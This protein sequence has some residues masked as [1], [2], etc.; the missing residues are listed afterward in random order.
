VII[1]IATGAALVIALG[2]F[3]FHRRVVELHHE[4]TREAVT[5]TAA[6]TK[7][8]HEESMKSLD[9]LENRWLSVQAA[10]VGVQKAM[11]VQTLAFQRALERFEQM[12]D[13]MATSAEQQTKILGTV[14]DL[15]RNVRDS[16][17]LIETRTRNTE[18]ALNAHIKRT[19]P[20]I[21]QVAQLA[22][23]APAPRRPRRRAK[24]S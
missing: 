22:A 1:E 21:E 8:Q 6:V 13:R 5:A 2:A 11:E 9:A 24:S 4:E 7:A 23:C 16:A 10:I 17:F 14:T 3:L 19:A 20:A 18:D 12:L 15:A